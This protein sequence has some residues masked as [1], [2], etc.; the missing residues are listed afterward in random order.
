MPITSALSKLRHGHEEPKEQHLSPWKSSTPKL[1]R[2]RGSCNLHVPA[3]SE[4][5]SALT[6]SYRMNCIIRVQRSKSMSVL[7]ASKTCY[8]QDLVDDIDGRLTWLVTPKEHDQS[9]SIGSKS[10]GTSGRSGSPITAHAGGSTSTAVFLDDMSAYEAEGSLDGAVSLREST[11]SIR[12][13]MLHLSQYRKLWGNVPVSHSSSLSKSMPLLRSSHLLDK[14]RIAGSLSP[15]AAPTAKAPSATPT[16]TLRPIKRKRVVDRGVHISMQNESEDEREEFNVPLS[17][18]SSPAADGSREDH[19]RPL[20]KCGSNEQTN[21]HP[22]SLLSIPQVESGKLELPSTLSTGLALMQDEHTV[23]SLS[24]NQ[25][26]SPSTEKDIF[27]QSLHT[28]L[29]RLHYELSP[30]FRSP[31]PAHWKIIDDNVPFWSQGPHKLSMPS[32]RRQNRRRTGRTLPRSTASL[33]ALAPDPTGPSPELNSWRTT[34]NR[35]RCRTAPEPLRALAPASHI[36]PALPDETGIDTAAWILRQPPDGIGP[37][38]GAATMLYL[39][40]FGRA[41]TLTAWQHGPAAPPNQKRTSSAASLATPP[42]KT[43]RRAAPMARLRLRKDNGAWRPLAFVK[44][45]PSDGA[46]ESGSSDVSGSR[47]AGAVVEVQGDRSS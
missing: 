18:W 2:S 10:C 38:P 11:T 24:L 26:D 9:K 20:M 15:F 4:D 22:L 39:G 45:P 32:R 29:D 16:S 28:K 41:R 1:Y 34:L 47:R 43:L 36:A 35:L 3:N 14:N 6:A 40:A 42:R 7:D 19:H 17:F 8:D 21:F 12:M 27:V 13:D 37:D 46:L 44:P 25:S 31:A 23:A 5:T 33:P 30:G